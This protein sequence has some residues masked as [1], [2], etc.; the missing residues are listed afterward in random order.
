LVC[1]E[2]V[3]SARATIRVSLVVLQ[4]AGKAARKGGKPGDGYIAKQNHDIGIGSRTLTLAAA[5][6][7]GMI[8]GRYAE[9]ISKG[10]K[11]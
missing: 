1:A 11:Q 10:K 2:G 9:E 7:K 5:P 4:R 6:G 8:C 3:Q